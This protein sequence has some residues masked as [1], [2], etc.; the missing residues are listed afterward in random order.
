MTFKTLRTQ[1]I[2]M[3]FQPS[4]L[5]IV[6]ATLSPQLANAKSLSQTCQS[7]FTTHPFRDHY[8]NLIRS[9]HQAADSMA[10]VKRE[11][12]NKRAQEI[13][14]IAEG[15]AVFFNSNRPRHGLE[16]HPMRHNFIGEHLGNSVRLEGLVVH[17]FSPSETAAHRVVFKDG[18][19]YWSSTG[20]LVKDTGLVEFVIGID[21]ELYVKRPEDAKL[22]D[23]FKHSSFFRG[24]PVLAPGM[25]EFDNYGEIGRLGRKSGH[26]RPEEQVIYDARNYLV[27]QGAE[28]GPDF[29]IDHN[30]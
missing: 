29:W 9:Y 28:L 30:L 10:G 7:L 23:A 22:G 18:K 19:A 16:A 12:L 2:L 6:L 11:D 13:F 1:I 5:L 25:I 24:E 4:L 3:L 27:S 8:D 17:Y 14:A 20:E 21:G 26:Y 15:A